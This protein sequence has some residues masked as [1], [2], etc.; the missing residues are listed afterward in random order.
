MERVCVTGATGF[1]AT[2]IVKQLLEAGYFVRGTVRNPSDSQKIKPLIEI[3]EKANA[4]DRLEI[5]QADL[6]E[7]GSFDDAVN[8]CKFVMHTASPFQLQARGDPYEY[9]VR[10][11]VFGTDNVLTSVGKSDSVER[12]V[13]TSSVAA[14]SG[15][16]DD[17]NRPYTEED[18]N[19]SSTIE[20]G[21]SYSLSKRL[22]EE[23]AWELAKNQDKYT[24]VTINPSLVIGPTL[25]GR[26]DTASVD[27]MKKLIDGPFAMG[28]PELNI[29]VVDVRDVA[30]AHILAIKTPSAEG[31]YICSC[32]S[33]SAL[34]MAA[35]IAQKYPNYKLPRRKVPKWL[36]YIFGPFQGL[37]WTFISHNIGV[38]LEL[39]NSKIKKDLA[40]EFTPPL[41]SFTDM[42]DSMVEA[43]LVTDR[44]GAN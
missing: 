3:A 33:M 43:G 2:H 40:F 8:D 42:I 35:V 25:T 18:W 29:G 5:V 9:F 28:A 15:F 11:A 12:V 21:M 10:P 19:K 24:L 1:I 36:L 6:L 22:A 13:V 38:P 31:R 23:K 39:D 7:Q 41:D 27:F 32:Q 14:I 20:N 34:G 26:D 4:A 44:R 16:N 37:S 17:K 30:R